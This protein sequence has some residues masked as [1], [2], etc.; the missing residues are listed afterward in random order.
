MK[1]NVPV[2][3]SAQV[4]HCVS[5]GVPLWSSGYR[6][7]WDTWANI[8]RR[9]SSQEAIAFERQVR[10]GVCLTQDT[11]HIAMQPRATVWSSARASHSYI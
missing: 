1:S 8:A 11:V 3:I 9:A 10:L 2:S 7:V 4:F 5:W 6:V